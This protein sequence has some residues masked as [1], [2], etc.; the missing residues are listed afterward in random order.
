MLDRAV[1][2][3][4]SKAVNAV[5]IAASNKI[6]FRIA[7]QNTLQCISRCFWNMDKDKLMLR[8]YHALSLACENDSR[9]RQSQPQKYYEFALPGEVSKFPDKAADRFDT[10]TWHEPQGSR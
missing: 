3:R 7:A 8:P 5:L 1:S 10:L 9:A 4:E 6:I 2:A